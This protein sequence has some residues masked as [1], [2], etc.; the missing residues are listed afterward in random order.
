MPCRTV[1]AAQVLMNS[2][3]KVLLAVKRGENLRRARVR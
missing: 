2:E 3:G 1:E